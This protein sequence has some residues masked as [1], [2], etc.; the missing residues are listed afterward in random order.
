MKLWIPIFMLLACSDL[1][2]AIYG[3]SLTRTDTAIAL[4]ACEEANF[5]NG[6]AIAEA[7]SSDDPAKIASVLGDAMEE[8]R[9]TRI[10]SDLNAARR[11]CIHELVPVQLPREGE[12]ASQQASQPTTLVKRFKDLGIEYFYY[13]PD[14]AWTLEKNPVDLNILATSYLDSPWGRQAFLMMTRIGWSQGE[15]R[16]GPDQFREVINHSEQFLVENPDTEVSDS[17]RL[18]LANAYATWWN[19]SR[20]ERNPPYEYP[21]KYKVGAA[22]AKQRAVELYQGYL[23][24][25]KKSVPEVEKR[26]KALQEDPKGSGEFDYYCADYED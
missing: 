5:S 22:E 23:K 11:F 4:R 1:G 12:I 26:L 8:L 3:P 20:A 7:L 24:A 21:E 15:C 17:I 2:R 13:G 19:I 10:M 6:A 16:E 18:E 14:A 25:Q 9:T